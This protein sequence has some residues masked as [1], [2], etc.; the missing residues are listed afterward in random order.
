MAEHFDSLRTLPKVGSVLLFSE[1][2]PGVKVS[3]IK[4]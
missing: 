1:K 4:H 2:F 3:K